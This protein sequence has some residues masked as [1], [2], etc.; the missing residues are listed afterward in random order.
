M[1]SRQI[2]SLCGGNICSQST[3]EPIEPFRIAPAPS[4][5]IHTLI[6]RGEVPVAGLDLS[7]P[8]HAVLA[9]GDKLF[10]LP[11]ANKVALLNDMLDAHKASLLPSQRAALNFE[12]YVVESRG[13]VETPDPGPKECERVQWEVEGTV[14]VRSIV[15]SKLRWYAVPR[16]RGFSGVVCGASLYTE[17]ITLVPNPQAQKCATQADAER[18]WLETY[19]AGKCAKMFIVENQIVMKAMLPGRPDPMGV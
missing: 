16:G 11:N 15:P 10:D 5:T 9:S 17:L 14:I 4:Y 6:P 18:H 7:N 2:P 13:D 8:D 12:G 1:V 19:Y 3:S